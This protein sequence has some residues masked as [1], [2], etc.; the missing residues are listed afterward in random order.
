MPHTAAP[1][2]PHT[3]GAPPPSLRAL[4]CGQGRSRPVELGPLHTAAPHTPRPP[5]HHHHYHAPPP[6]MSAR[7]TCAATF[8][9][10]WPR[11]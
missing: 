4:P 10:S 1:G 3:P 11:T 6:P 7:L 8:C 5:H 2:I 9:S